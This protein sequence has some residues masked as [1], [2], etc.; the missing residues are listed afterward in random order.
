MTQ[1]QRQALVDRYYKWLHSDFL[2]EEEKTRGED[3]SQA[4]REGHLN[5]LMLAFAAFVFI[6]GDLRQIPPHDHQ[7]ILSAYGKHVRVYVEQKWLEMGV[8]PSSEQQ[9]LEREYYFWPVSVFMSSV[10]VAAESN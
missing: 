9:S 4:E 8:E 1:Q 2:L 10:V 5:R 7:A 3:Y 6:N